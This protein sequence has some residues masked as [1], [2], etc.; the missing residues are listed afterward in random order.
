MSEEDENFN[1]Q[2]IHIVHMLWPLTFNKCEELLMF[3]PVA[4][5]VDLQSQQ[6][7][8]EELVF[9]VQTPCCVL[10]HLEGHELYNVGDAFA[11]DRAFR[12]PVQAEF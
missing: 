2:K 9:F 11:G 4:L 1:R 3:D 6:Q 12:G 7:S 5:H 10:V 8:E